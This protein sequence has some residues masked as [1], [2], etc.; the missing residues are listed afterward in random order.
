MFEAH[1]ALRRRLHVAHKSDGLSV[2]IDRQN[3][4]GLYLWMMC[5]CTVG[6]AL[7]CNMLWGASIRHPHDVLYAT[8]P[9][10]ILGLVCYILALAIAIW[11]AFG[12]EDVSTQASSLRWTRT[13]LK[14]SRTIDIPIAEIT[15]IKAITP[16]HRLDNSVEVNTV[17]QQ[18]RIGGKL[19]RD[20]ALELAKHLRHAVG[21]R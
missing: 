20:E 11:G 6:F 9:M 16:W 21:L 13:A 10:F 17:R 1:S 19:L 5:L 12:V 15:E 3:T 2:R 7:F 14:W 18:R 4:R 8:L